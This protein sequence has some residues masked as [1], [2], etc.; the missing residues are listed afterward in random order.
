MKNKFVAL[1]FIAACLQAKTLSA[2]NDSTSVIKNGMGISVAPMLSMPSFV[3]QSNYASNA[4][5]GGFGAS[6]ALCQNI[7]LS[8][9]QNFY[10]FLELGYQTSAYINNNVPN[11]LFLINANGNVNY[12]NQSTFSLVNRFNYGFF[13]LSIQKVLFHFGK[14]VGIFAGI[15]AQVSYCYSYSQVAKNLLDTTGKNISSNYSTT[16]YSVPQDNQLAAAAVARLGLM[17][18]P[19]K[20]LGIN[21]APVFN[22]GLNPKYLFEKNNPGFNSLGLNVQIM[23]NF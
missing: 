5:K 11:T 9:K 16:S 4:T 15:G 17:L 6:A 2:K 14:K 19:V 22:Y 20:H 18:N 7:V 1:L 8:K 13:S 12:N 23:Y 21:I 3:N 10:L